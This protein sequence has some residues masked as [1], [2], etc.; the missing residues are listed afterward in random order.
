MSDYVKVGKASS[1]RKGRGRVFQVNGEKVVVFRDRD[2]LVAV[3]DECPHMGASLVDGRLV[4]GFIECSWHHWRYD[5]RTGVSD[6][7]D[8]ACVAVYDVKVEEDDLLLRPPPPAGPPQEEPAPETG[9]ED[10]IGWDTDRYFRKKPE[11]N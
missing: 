3:S 2:G 4:D 9:D 8:W 1:V 7:R 5:V 11:G 10:W 6:Q